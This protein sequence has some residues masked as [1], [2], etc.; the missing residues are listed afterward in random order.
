MGR[1]RT[2]CLPMHSTTPTTSALPIT[3]ARC[4]SVTP[5]VW[6]SGNMFAR[7]SSTGVSRRILPLS[8]T[9]TC[10]LRDG[11]LPPSLVTMVRA[12]ASSE[13]GNDMAP[14]DHWKSTPVCE[15]VTVLRFAPLTYLQRSSVDSS[16]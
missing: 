3:N 8:S 15:L 13:S 5:R 10:V 4:A 11:L 6:L 12:G 7:S 2:P 16:T 14:S 9:M 1:E